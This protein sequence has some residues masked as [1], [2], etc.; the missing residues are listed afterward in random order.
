MR[1]DLTDLR[2]FLHVHQAGTITGGA[3]A[4]HLTLASASERIRGMEAALGLPLLLREPR[5]VVPT[6]AGHTLLLHARRVL[7]QMDDLQAE[8]SDYAGGLKGQVRLLCN[9]SALSEHLPAVLGLFL[10]GHPGIS[11]DMEERASSDIA[12]ALRAGLCDIGLVSDA[13][14][15]AGLETFVFR[16][17]PL[18]L[19]VPEGHALSQRRSVCLADVAG[20]AFVGLAAGSAL[21]AHLAQQARRLGKRLVYRVRLRSFESVCRLVGEGIGVGIVPQAVALRVARSAAVRRIGLTDAWARRHLL[22]AVREADA[23]PACAQQLLAHLRT[24]A[25][26]AADAPGPLTAAATRP[27][28]RTLAKTAG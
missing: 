23:L 2:L 28:P 7:R 21:Q 8:L 22:V 4:S 26:S 11:L 15:V 9:T 27:R 5:G 13:A 20:C 17:D 25:A 3:E 12:D 6:P 18:V 10:A 16:A 14:D 24:H 1:I 19:V